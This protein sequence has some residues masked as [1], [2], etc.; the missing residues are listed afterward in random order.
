M[1]KIELK[2]DSLTD[3]Q[4]RAFGDRWVTHESN[5][6]AWAKPYRDLSNFKKSCVDKSI[7]STDV[8]TLNY[9]I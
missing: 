5:L 6:N 3:A 1:E 8:K 2:W 9:V 4:K 7:L